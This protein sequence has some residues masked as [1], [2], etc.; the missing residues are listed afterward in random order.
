[1]TA[2][3]I[4]P[5]PA[6]LRRA[7]RRQDFHSHTAGQAPGHAQGN[8]AILPRDYADEFLRFCRLNPKSCPVIGMT[9][10]GDPSVPELGAG[11]DLRHDVPAYC[12]FRDGEFSGEVAD[13]C[14]LWRDDLVGFVI[15]C[16]LSFEA[17]LIDALVPVRHIENDHPVPMYN[18]S[19]RNT[20]AGRFGGNMV[21]SMRP[22]TPAQAIR[23]I[24]VTS[25]FP[26]V[27]GAPVHTWAIPQES[28]SPI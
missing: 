6:D 12:V 26:A 17:A 20:P 21:V 13:L 11:I 7:I 22:M 19:I 10:P 5:I 3:S 16:S 4:W 24:Q 2:P 25:R 23:A 27:H 1:M 18:T 28:A 8:L 14:E 9:E 15:G